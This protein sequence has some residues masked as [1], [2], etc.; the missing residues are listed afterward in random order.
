M[1]LGV[2]SEALPQGIYLELEGGGRVLLP[3]NECEGI[4][5]GDEL[6]V[7]VYLDSEDRPV[8]TRKEPRAKA[9][10]FAVLMVRDVN[11]VGAFLD[12][13]L[14]KDLFL[15]FHNQLGELEVGDPS[16]VFIEQDERSGRLVATEK[17]RPYFER[18]TA[19]LREG[20]EVELIAYDFSEDG[21]ID[22]VVE[23]RY[24]GRWHGDPLE[25]GLHIGD[26]TRGFIQRIREEG[27]LSI[28]LRP[29]GKKA[30]EACEET[31]LSALRQAGGF[32]PL[33]D[34]TNPERIQEQ[35]GMS[36]KSFKKVAGNLWK[37]GRVKLLEDGIQLIQ[38]R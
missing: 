30:R 5:P 14:A 8:A 31:L 25:T 17:L 24:T 32:L 10:E 28:S 35:L 15:P 33:T 34:E 16:V 12:W 4:E 26:H 3:R 20:Q 23:H 6:V 21:Y 36:K 9:G 7:F 1:N 38:N 29:V 13:G 22:F 27:L 11:D 18:N 2:A 37:R 19:A